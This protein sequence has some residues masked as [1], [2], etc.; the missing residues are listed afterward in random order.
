MNGPDADAQEC[1][2]QYPGGVIWDLAPN[3]PSRCRLECSARAAPGRMRGGPRARG[4]VVNSPALRRP[5]APA[6][7][8]AVCGVSFRTW[9][10]RLPA[11]RRVLRRA[12]WP[13]LLVGRFRSA[14]CLLICFFLSGSQSH[15]HVR[16]HRPV[17][18]ERTCTR[19]EPACT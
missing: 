6:M 4:R 17:R 7:P 13:E 1:R 18:I 10:G 2:T 9:P 12:A 8:C 15:D 19:H 16:V 5:P 3:W 14:L 11:R